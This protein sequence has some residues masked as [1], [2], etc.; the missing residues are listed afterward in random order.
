MHPFPRIPLL[1]SDRVSEGQD[2]SSLVVL[3]WFFSLTSNMNDGAPPKVRYGLP[4]DF[5]GEWS[6]VSFSK[7]YVTDY[8]HKRVAFGPAEVAVHSLGC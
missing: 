5:V 8:V 2:A 1:L 7:E 4:Q 6:S 3:Q